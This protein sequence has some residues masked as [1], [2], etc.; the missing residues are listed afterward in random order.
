MAYLPCLLGPHKHKGRN[1]NLYFGI[2][3]QG[4]MERRSG[5]ACVLHWG[6]IERDLAQFEVDSDS[7]TLSDPTSE[8]LCF[9][10]FKPVDK[11]RCQVFVTAYPAKDERKDYWA[12]IHSTCDLNAR[13]RQSTRSELA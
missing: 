4:E 1:V 12:A 2:A 9:T 13:L 3:R 6:E 7:G 8:G 10:C 11:S 5:R